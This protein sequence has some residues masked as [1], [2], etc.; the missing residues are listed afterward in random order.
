MQKYQK[1]GHSRS[2]GQ[3]RLRLLTAS[4]APSTSL[5]PRSPLVS[6]GKGRTT[7]LA[8]A[9]GRNCGLDNT[10]EDTMDIGRGCMMFIGS[11]PGEDVTDIDVRTTGDLGI[12]MGV[13]ME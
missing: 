4:P 5:I 7:G 10:G 12:A 1:K 2:Q 13:V 9:T 8:I 11:P 6:L 3:P